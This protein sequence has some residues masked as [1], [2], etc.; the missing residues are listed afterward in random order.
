MTILSTPR[1][2][3]TR[4]LVRQLAPS[5]AA[6]VSKHPGSATIDMALAHQQHDAYEQAVQQM[7]GQG[8]K[9]VQVP[10]DQAHPDCCFVEDTCVTIRN[11][12]VFTHPGHVSRQGEVVGIKK[13][14]TAHV[15]EIEHVYSMEAPATMDG[16]DVLFT[17]AHL[18]IGLSDRT[19]RAGADFLAA[20]MT[21][22]H[23]TLA[24]VIA[25]LASQ[26]TLHFKCVMTFLTH[27]VLVISDDEPGHLAWNQIPEPVRAAYHVIW[28]PDQVASNVL[29]FP[30]GKD[31]LAGVIVQEGFP[32][33]EEI[34]KSEIEARFPGTKIV[35]LQM[36]EFIKADGAL[37]CCSLL[38]A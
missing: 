19:N 9:I 28:V 3:F 10:T 2:R 33:S 20:M 17:G 22:H 36:S 8:T 27:N 1:P 5:F 6:A 31:G 16:G 34:L 24:V 32:A 25:D 4:A 18:F 35:P 23:P 15:P 29:S 12:A 7:L 26:P 13:A 30:D 37:T 21:K 14:I 11:V 38:F